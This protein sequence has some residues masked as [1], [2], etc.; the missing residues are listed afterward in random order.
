MHQQL[1]SHVVSGGLINGKAAWFADSI[2]KHKDRM[3]KKR[4]AIRGPELCLTAESCVCVSSFVTEH[5]EVLQGFK[6][7]QA[8]PRTSSSMTG[9]VQQR[10]VS[11]T[12]LHDSKTTTPEY[13][14]SHQAVAVQSMQDPCAKK[15]VHVTLSKSALATIAAFT[16]VARP[17]LCAKRPASSR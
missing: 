7:L 5:P 14:A 3:S 6:V 10:H 4:P 11:C 12:L 2:L 13:P 16:G 15:S 8:N 17:A 1:H 9:M